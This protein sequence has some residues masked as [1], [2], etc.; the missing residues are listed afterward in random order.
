MLNVNAAFPFFIPVIDKMITG[1]TVC[2]VSH[3]LIRDT[4]MIQ[5]CNDTY[6][7]VCYITGILT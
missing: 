1:S 3:N 4:I 7:T 5:V 2:S 6:H